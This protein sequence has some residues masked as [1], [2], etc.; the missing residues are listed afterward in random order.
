MILDTESLA[1]RL[2]GIQSAARHTMIFESNFIHFILF[3]Y[4]AVKL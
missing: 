2:G 1:I 4:S 3:T